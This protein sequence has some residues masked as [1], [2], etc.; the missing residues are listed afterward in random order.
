MSFLVDFIFIVFFSPILLSSFLALVVSTDFFNGRVI[1]YCAGAGGVQ[2][3]LPDCYWYSIPIGV[4]IY[5]NG[6]IFSKWA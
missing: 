5:Q 4:K 1:V 6:E 3:G 2:A